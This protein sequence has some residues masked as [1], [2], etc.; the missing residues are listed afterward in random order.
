[1][2]QL[3]KASFQEPLHAEPGDLRARAAGARRPNWSAMLCL[4]LPRWIPYCISYT[5][6]EAVLGAADSLRPVKQTS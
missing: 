1:M 4:R 3:P 2:T 5:S 6:S